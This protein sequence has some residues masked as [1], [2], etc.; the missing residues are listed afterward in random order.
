MN[1]LECARGNPQKNQWW[2]Y[3]GN[4]ALSLVAANTIGVIPFAVV[5]IF[6]IVKNIDTITPNPENIMDFSVYGVPQNLS[7]ALM[8]FAFVAALIALIFFLKPFHN[9]TFQQV[10]NGTNKIRWKYFFTGLS[11]WLIISII[12][13]GIGLWLNPS[14]YILQ[15]DIS[16]FVP[17][18]IITVLLI[19][20]QTTYEEVSFRGYLAQG[21]AAYTSNRW[22]TIIIPGVSFGLLHSLNPEIAT[23]GFWVM[24]P[25]YI[26]F[27]LFFGLVAVLD[28]GIETAMGIHA[29]NNMFVCLFTTSPSSALQTPAVFN[30]PEIDPI[31]SG[32]TL[33]IASII[34][35]AV[36]YKIQKW[37]FRVLN[38]KIESK[39]EQQDMEVAQ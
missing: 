8:L 4:L 25:Q 26:F 28:D 32:I 17:L 1:H 12:E 38:K 34:A 5:L 16:T 31:G 10:I 13:L 27:G 14:S 15:F 6:Y 9:R 37:D 20:I 2:K 39:N 7:L 24:M 21:V 30:V 35:L 29:A 19:P 3:L 22:W 36:L 18:V 11:V 23:H 33:V